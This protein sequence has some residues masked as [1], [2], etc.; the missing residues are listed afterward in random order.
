MLSYIFRMKFSSTLIAPFL[1]CLTVSIQAQD[2]APTVQDLQS[3]IEILKKQI[4]ELKSEFARMKAGVPSTESAAEKP[5]EARIPSKP[6]QVGPDRIIDTKSKPGVDL[7]KGFTLTPYGAVYFGAFGNSAGTNNSDVPLWASTSAGGGMS[8]SVRQSRLGVRVDGG[9]LWNAA[10]TASVEGDFFGGYP[11]NGIGEN[12]GV[13]R[14]RQANVRLSWKKTS[15]LIGQEGSVFA[16]G[17]PT[18]LGAFAIPMLGASGNAWSRQAQFRVE[19]KFSD[20]LSFQGAVL[21]PQTGDFPAAGTSPQLLQPGAG[22]ASMLPFFQGRIALSAGNWFGT[23]QAALFGVS[24][25]YGRSRL[26]TGRTANDFD[27]VGVAVDWNVPLSDRAGI[28]GEYFTG[29]NLGGLQ[30]GVFQGYNP[31]FAHINGSTVIA[32]GARGIG[33]TGGWSQISLRPDA[34]GD[35]VTFYGTFGLDDPRNKDL[36]SV[37]VRDWRSRNLSYAASMIFKPVPQIS[38]GAEFKRLETNYTRS[39]KKQVSH[40]NLGAAYSF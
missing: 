32:G 3:E 11:S 33:T 35:R 13:F 6:A 29:R 5:S 1:A 36:A 9:R 15:V 37:S 17:N 23:K 24:G 38:I 26:G 2:K 12:F 4:S 30:A 16:P 18:S 7:G 34:F 20:K 19:H 40:F 39:G 14:L 25:H 22:A 31:D 28:A 21:S 8:A 10:M 27:S